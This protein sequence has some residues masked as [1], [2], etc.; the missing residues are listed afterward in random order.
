METNMTMADHPLSDRVNDDS[1]G[2]DVEPADVV[3]LAQQGFVSREYRRGGVLVYKLRWRRGHRQ[4]VRF[5]GRDANRAAAVQAWLD[6]LQRPGRLARQAT[7]LLRDARRELRQ[8][9]DLL[10]P[11]ASAD[12]SHYHGYRLRRRSESITNESTAVLPKHSTFQAK[13]ATGKEVLHEP[14]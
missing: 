7:K 3:L 5:L 8:A 10:I 1:L 2:L 14:E 13:S 12:G 6:D 9:K 11:R 4:I